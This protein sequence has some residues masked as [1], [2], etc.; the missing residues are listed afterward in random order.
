MPDTQRSSHTGLPDELLWV[1]VNDGSSS[2]SDIQLWLNKWCAHI[3][4]S[5]NT[6][7]VPLQARNITTTLEVSA[8]RNFLIS[9]PHRELV[10]FFLRGVV[11]GFRIGFT[12]GDYPPLISAEKNLQSAGEHP[13]VIDKY[14]QKEVD[15]QRVVGPLPQA[16]VPG[17]HISRFGVIPKSHQPNSWRLIVDLSYPKGRSINNS[18]PKELCS[19]SYITIDDAIQGF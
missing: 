13:E 15:E 18:I 11:H 16:M 3:A 10:H 6:L 9:Q 2:N 4:P 19:M 8:W 1:D 7:V 17:L 12:H 5:P 14:L